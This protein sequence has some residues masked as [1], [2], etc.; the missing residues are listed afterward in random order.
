MRK[1]MGIAEK[2]VVTAAVCEAVSRLPAGYS[3][4]DAVVV[5]MKPLHAYGA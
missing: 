4:P 3:Q 5:I 1:L 2:Q